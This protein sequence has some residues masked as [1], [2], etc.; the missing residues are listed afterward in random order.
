MFTKKMYK[1]AEVYSQRTLQY[2]VCVCSR[3]GER[4]YDEECGNLCIKKKRGWCTRGKVG[5]RK[6]KI[7]KRKYCSENEKGMKSMM[8]R[9]WKLRRKRSRRDFTMSRKLPQIRLEGETPESKIQVAN[10]WMEKCM[11]IYR[12]ENLTWFIPLLQPL[13]TSAKLERSLV[14]TAVAF[15]FTPLNIQRSLAQNG[16]G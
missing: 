9:E 14:Y 11:N 4:C 3:K 5:K 16:M 15:A 10:C 8:K 6:K 12:I 1:I 13:A 2:C 7:N